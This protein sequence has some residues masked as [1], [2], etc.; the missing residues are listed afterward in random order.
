[1]FI[2]GQ[3]SKDTSLIIPTKVQ[4]LQEKIV[5]CSIGKFSYA[6]IDETQMVWMWGDNKQGQLGLSDYTPR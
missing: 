2:W 4:S 3:V 1:M 6:A 5:D